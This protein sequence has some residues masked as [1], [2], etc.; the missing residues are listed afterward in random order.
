MTD[1][2]KTYR[3]VIRRALLYDTETRAAKTAHENDFVVGETRSLRWMCIV[4]E[5]DR[6]RNK[7]IRGSIREIG[8]SLRGKVQERRLRRNEHLM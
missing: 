6:T 7:R 2:M 1:K 5:L 3:T 4:T 8:K